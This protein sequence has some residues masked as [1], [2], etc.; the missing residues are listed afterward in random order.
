MLTLLKPKKIF[1]LWKNL[2]CPTSQLKGKRRLS[3]HLFQRSPRTLLWTNLLKLCRSSP[4]LT[5]WNPVRSLK[6]LWLMQV[7]ISCRKTNS[8]AKTSWKIIWTVWYSSK[9]RSE[10]TRQNQWRHPPKRKTIMAKYPSILTNSTNSVNKPTNRRYKM[11]RTQSFPLV[12]GWCQRMS[13]KLPLQ[14]SSSPK[15]AQMTSL[16]VCQSPWSQWRWFRREKSWKKKW[17]GWKKRSIRSQRKKSTFKF[18]KN[19]IYSI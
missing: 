6:A 16:N 2:L 8:N 14:I 7:A 9:T 12:P 18:E 13:A 17:R 4:R 5:S 11:R 19:K 15:K 3:S 1:N 10:N